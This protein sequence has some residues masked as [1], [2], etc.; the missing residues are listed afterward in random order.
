MLRST[1]KISV[2]YFTPNYRSTLQ[3]PHPSFPRR[4]L[5]VPNRMTWIFFFTF[6]LLSPSNS[7]ADSLLVLVQPA[8]K[9]VRPSTTHPVRKVY[10]RFFPRYFLFPQVREPGSIPR[11]N[12]DPPLR[13]RRRDAEQPR[14]QSS[15]TLS[16]A[17]RTRPIGNRAGG[18]LE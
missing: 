18:D 9:S 16:C 13:P 17:T 6:F 12:R 3:Y 11:T 1:K 4:H 14:P 7:L 15:R 8:L 2:L 10:G 5:A